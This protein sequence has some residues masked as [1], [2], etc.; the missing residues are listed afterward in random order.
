MGDDETGG[1]LQFQRGQEAF[2]LQLGR[3]FPPPIL[4]QLLHFYE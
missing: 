4:P 2:C 1:H 3:H